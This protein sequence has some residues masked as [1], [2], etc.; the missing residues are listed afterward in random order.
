[1]IRWPAYLIRFLICLIIAWFPLDDLDW[2]LYSERLH[3][4]ISDPPPQNIWFI[5]TPT[6]PSS[7]NAI[8][9][10]LQDRGAQE[11]WNDEKS[12][13]MVEGGAQRPDTDGVL[14]HLESNP[15]GP[16]IHF[17]GPLSKFL[18]CDWKSTCALE[19]QKNLQGKVIFVVPQDAMQPQGG[20]RIRTPM[21]EL[22]PS[23]VAANLLYTKYNDR[24]I[25]VASPW[26]RSMVLATLIIFTSYLILYFPSWLAALGVSTA[27]AFINLLLF[28]VFFQFFDLYIPAANL[29]FGMLITYLVYTGYRLAVQENLQWRSLK[30]SQYLKEVDQMKTNFVSLVSH[31]LKT[32]IAKIQAVVERLKRE[33]TLPIGE[34]SDWRLLLESIEVS[35]RELKHYINSILNLSRIEAQKILVKKKSNDVNQIVRSALK[36]FQPAAAQK[37]IQIRENLEPLFSIECD[38]DLIRQVISNLIDNAL[39]YSPEGSEI[40]VKTYEGEDSVHI[41]VRDT[42]PGIPKDQLPLMFRKFTRF[43]RPV[44]GQVKGTGLGLYLSKYFIELHGGTIKVESE[45]GQGTKFSFTL[46]LGNMESGALLG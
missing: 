34:R 7:L 6:D 5:T 31:D 29:I 13:A 2:Q 39:K 15:A 21:G 27:G 28:Q 26:L 38:E 9:A 4:K 32:P 42:G 20:P 16:L 25:T 44:R 11:I 12:R 41:E 33:Q 10:E 45:V 8:Q 30:Q 37:N 46:P 43:V 17:R 24:P 40:W 23:E 36:R 35:N 1:M 18:N 19:L 3:W 14:R 22:S